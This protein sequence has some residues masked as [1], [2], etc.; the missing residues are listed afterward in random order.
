MEIQTSLARSRKGERSELGVA[1][2]HG[3]GKW[4]LRSIDA[5][6]GG[7]FPPFPRRYVRGS[8]GTPE[9]GASSRV[10]ELATRLPRGPWGFRF[11]TLVSSWLQRHDCRHICD[12]HKLSLGLHKELISYRRIENVPTIILI[13]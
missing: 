9:D 13:L 7:W 11:G 5:S 10:G 12:L 4:R 3:A 1:T 8:Y 6:V 2:E